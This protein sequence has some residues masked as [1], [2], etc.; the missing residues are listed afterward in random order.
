MSY[1]LFTPLE[2]AVNF[3]PHVLFN[4]GQRHSITITWNFWTSWCYI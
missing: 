4:Q 1:A 3:S 2:S